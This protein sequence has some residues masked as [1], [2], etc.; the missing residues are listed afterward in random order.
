M[1]RSAKPKK[2]KRRRVAEDEDEQRPSGD[3]T[4]VSVV[5]AASNRHTIN[6]FSVGRSQYSRVVSSTNSFSLIQLQT[7]GVKRAKNVVQT[8]LV[9]SEREIVPQQYAGDATYETQI[10]T[11]KDR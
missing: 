1:F 4:D 9:E 11:E 8:Q 10:D 5:A 3:N 2:N 6:T 7:G